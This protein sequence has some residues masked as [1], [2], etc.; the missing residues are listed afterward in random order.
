MTVIE[1]PRKADIKRH[2]LVMRP[3]GYFKNR[4]THNVSQDWLDRRGNPQ[5]GHIV[6]IPGT[7]GYVRCEIVRI[8][9]IR[10]GV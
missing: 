9:P 5:V 8:T 4:I 1:H 7:E 2:E 6:E 10:E 3:I